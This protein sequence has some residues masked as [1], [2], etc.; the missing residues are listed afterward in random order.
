MKTKM[1][2][3]AAKTSFF[4]W[5]FA[6]L[7]I[8]TSD[9][10]LGLLAKEAAGWQQF[11]MFKGLG[12]VAITAILLYLGLHKQL[13]RYEQ[14]EKA[15]KQSEKKYRALFENMSEGFAFFAPR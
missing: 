1:I 10:W 11:Q 15:L 3:I 5:L 14:S 2:G 6:S 8:L 9:Y 13:Q 12:F 4:Y 7:Y